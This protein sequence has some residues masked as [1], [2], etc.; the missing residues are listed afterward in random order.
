MPFVPNAHRPGNFRMTSTTVAPPLSTTLL[1]LN[2]QAWHYKWVVT[3]IVLVAGATQSSASTSVNLAIPRLMA[4]FGTD[5]AAT[6]WVATGFLLTRTL[7]MPLLGWLGGVLGNRN[8][9]VGIMIGYVIT[10]IGCGLSTSLAMLVSFR[11]L[12][13]LIMGT[14]EGVTVMILVG[15]FPAQ[16]RGMALGLR[17]I[18]WASGQ[19]VFFALG[20]YLIEQVS[21]RL[22][23]FLGVPFGITAGVFGL[24]VLPQQ[25][26]YRGLPVDYPGII[27]L[28]AFLVPLLLFISLGRKTDTE[29]S[30]LVLLALSAVG[31]GGLFVLRELL[32]VFPA[33]NL[34]LFRSS[35]F[36]FV[37]VSA[38]FNNM[39][40]F[41]SLFMLPIFLQQVIGLN[42]FQT[43]LVMVPA[44]VVS[45]L[46]GVVTGRASDLLP[47]ELVVIVMMLTLTVLFY[48][49]ST[50]TAL[51]SIAVIVGYLILH[52]VCMNG[53]ITPLVVLTVRTFEGDQ[54]R[55]GQGLMGVVRSIG[56]SLGVTV[57][58]V[59]FERQRT[60]HQLTAY[61]TYDT[62]SP[63]YYDVLR[64][65]KL[66]LHH[67]G[68]VG[69]AVERMALGTI[70]RQMDI[71]AIA[72]AFQ[73]SFLMIAVFFLLAGLPMFYLLL[74]RQRV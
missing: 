44:L 13:G 34:R 67:A 36:R 6:Q 15:V 64:E 43:G 9:F 54:V 38:F 50:I 72:V 73:D 28:G 19:I 23:F 17:T 58:S 22:A 2:T 7:M 3:S 65:L 21:W 61:A 62:T 33:V 60:L 40:L 63:A 45:G 14:M 48:A 11:L 69:G 41:G 32:T 51:T 66:F 35:T 74:R 24:L 30:T 18:G 20:G 4:A 42:P 8:L 12:Q 1:R 29:T 70:R 49:F 16:Q 31:G 47:P 52:R 37:C 26:E 55:M 56:A 39:A 5:L 57:T 25:R 10:T 46:T 71:E 53:S 68:L 59:F 27:A